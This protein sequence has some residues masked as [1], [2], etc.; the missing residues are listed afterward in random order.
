MGPDGQTDVRR[1]VRCAVEVLQASRAEIGALRAWQT[2]TNC[3]WRSKCRRAQV[4]WNDFEGSATCQ[5]DGDFSF[6]NWKLVRESQRPAILAQS[7]SWPIGKVRAVDRWQMTVTRKAP[8]GGRDINRR[9]LEKHHENKRLVCIQTHGMQLMDHKW[10][11]LFPWPH[12]RLQNNSNEI[13]K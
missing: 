4:Y 6:A 7:S 13:I 2:Q 3:Q 11:P 8:R 9:L 10:P 5:K 1:S 12:S